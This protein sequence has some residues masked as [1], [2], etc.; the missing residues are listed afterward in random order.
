MNTVG[1]YTVVTP[2]T[3]CF[4]EGRGQSMFAS[5]GGLLSKNESGDAN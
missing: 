3:T 4:E 1:S 5:F 2:T